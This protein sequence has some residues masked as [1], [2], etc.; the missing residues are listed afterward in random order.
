MDNTGYKQVNRQ[1]KVFS[2]NANLPLAQDIC[3]HL[4]IPIGKINLTSF[5][6]GEVYCQILEN[7]RGTDAFLVQPTCCPVNHNLMELLI[8]ID[9]FK[10]SSAARITAVIPYY[11][12]A[13]QDRKDKPRADLV[14]LVADLLTA[15]GVI[16]F[17]PWICT[18][19]RYRAF[20]HTSGSPVR[21]RF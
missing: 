5:S 17:S 7:V 10:R 4:Q 3:E 16:A 11:G 14:K 20:R 12:Y 8:M 13:R 18:P 9:A 2:G 6:D 15:A 1:L 21:R 19:V